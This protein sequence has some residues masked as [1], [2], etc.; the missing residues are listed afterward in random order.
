MSLTDTVQT[1]REHKA[2]TA[3]RY[4]TYGAGWVALAFSLIMLWAILYVATYQVFADAGA[5]ETGFLEP[6]FEFAFAIPVGAAMGAEV[7]LI[8]DTVGGSIRAWRGAVLGA[9]VLGVV[10]VVSIAARGVL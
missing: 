5:F 10:K 2:T 4:L 1:Y 6:L 7:A 9:G 3:A 8:S